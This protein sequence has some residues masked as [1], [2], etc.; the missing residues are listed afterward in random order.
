METQVRRGSRNSTCKGPGVGSLE[1]QRPAW[2]QPS[3]QGGIKSVGPQRSHQ[4]QAGQGKISV[5][6]RGD[7]GSW[8]TGVFKQGSGVP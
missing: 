8:R 4:D 2:L 1:A 6:F 3:D 5:S 7:K